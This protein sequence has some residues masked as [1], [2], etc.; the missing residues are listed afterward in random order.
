MADVRA[1]Q[2]TEWEFPQ[3]QTW[4]T[5]TPEQQQS[6]ML[7][8]YEHRASAHVGMRDIDDDNV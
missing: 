7:A 2:G 8:E 6:M 4:Q 1:F 5:L 3:E